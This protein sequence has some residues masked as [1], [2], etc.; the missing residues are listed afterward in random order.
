MRECDRTGRTAT[1]VLDEL[2]TLLVLDEGAGGVLRGRSPR[3]SLPFVYG[4]LLAA[5]ALAAAYRSVDRP[6]RVH[7]LHAYFLAAGDPRADLLYEV[8]EIRDSPSFAV[9]RVC[10]RQGERV[11]FEATMS[12]SI[13]VPGLEHG[14]APNCLSDDPGDLPQLGAWLRPHHAVLPDWWTGPMAIDLR[15]PAQPPHVL[16]SALRSGQRLWMRAVASLPEDARLHECVFTFAS[17]LTLLDPVLLANGK[18][19]YAGGIR[20]ASLDHA[21]WFHRRFP[22]DGWVLYEQASPASYGGRGL[23]TGDVFTADGTLCA[24]VAQQGLVRLIT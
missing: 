13:D 4:G 20:G 6:L 11:V 14:R 1:D 17:D 22:I 12:F 23:G 5:Q 7:S 3:R 9:R 24:S 15:Y 18:S 10:A 16:S 2:L 8:M 19:W 21:I